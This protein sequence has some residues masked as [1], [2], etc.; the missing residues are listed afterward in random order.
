MEDTQPRAEPIQ[1]PFIS[2]P[3]NC[4]PGYTQLEDTPTYHDV[5]STAN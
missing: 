1:L 4:P 3:S 5:M 2:C